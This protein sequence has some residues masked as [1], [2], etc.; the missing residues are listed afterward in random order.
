MKRHLVLAVVLTGSLLG[1]SAA[2]SPKP[3]QTPKPED[4]AALDAILKKMDDVSANFH[5]TQA[6]FEWDTYEKVI[7]EVDDVKTGVVYYRRAGKN[8]EMMAE[9]KKV[10]DS[11]ASAKPFPEYVLFSGGKIQLYEP[12][13]D[14]ITEVD[15]SKSHFDWETYV[16]LGFGGSGQDLKKNFD[17]TYQGS[18]EVNGIKAQKIELIPKSE[19]VRNTYSRI[20]LWID[21]D[22]GISVQQKFF[23]PQGDYKLAKYSNIKVNERIPDGV[24]KLKTTSKTERVSPVG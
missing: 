20:L 4:T 2:Q 23:S 16:V 24:F 8:I 1:F 19:K 5:A 9:V 14:R 7:D 11:A 3:A 12:K 22:R 17:V 15:L 6:D 13:P 10:G 18:E 21:P